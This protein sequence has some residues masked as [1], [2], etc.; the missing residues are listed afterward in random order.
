[1]RKNNIVVCSNVVNWDIISKIKPIAIKGKIIANIPKT[2]V[3]PKAIVVVIEEKIYQITA[4][5]KKIGFKNNIARPIAIGTIK[6]QPLPK[7]LLCKSQKK[8]TG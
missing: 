1:M 8:Y 4:A 5:I 2:T 6:Y 7:T 3:S